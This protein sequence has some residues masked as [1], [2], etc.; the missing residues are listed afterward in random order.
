MTNLTLDVNIIDFPSIPRGDVAHVAAGAAADARFD[1]AAL[2][3]QLDHFRSVA[4]LESQNLVERELAVGVCHI[5]VAPALQ[6][7]L[8]GIVRHLIKG[9]DVTAERHL[10]RQLVD[11]PAEPLSEKRHPALQGIRDD[12]RQERTGVLGGE[13]AAVK[14]DG[15]LDEFALAV[16]VIR[17]IV[18]FR[19]FLCL[20]IDPQRKFNLILEYR[21]HL[22]KFAYNPAN[23]PKTRGFARTTTPLARK[24]LFYN[25]VPESPEPPALQVVVTGSGRTTTPNLSPASPLSLTNIARRH[26]AKRLCTLC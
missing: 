3:Y 6:T 12:P 16:A 13:I 14:P 2:L 25:P 23:S 19:Q 15:L 11:H 24:R 4:P 26:A 7:F 10:Y 22:L 21:K 18:F 9:S 8:N 5:V 20:W 17:P 1:V